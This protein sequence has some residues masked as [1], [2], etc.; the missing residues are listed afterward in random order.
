MSVP[1][2]RAPLYCVV[3]LAASKKAELRVAGAGETGTAST[4]G[5]CGELPLDPSCPGL[6]LSLWPVPA[7]RGPGGGGPERVGGAGGMCVKKKRVQK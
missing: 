7:F 5:S 6:A 4:L 1:A 2:H 3:K